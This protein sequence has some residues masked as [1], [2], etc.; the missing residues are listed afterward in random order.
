[1]SL[2]SWQCR[3]EGLDSGLYAGTVMGLRGTDSDDVSILNTKY[4]AVTMGPFQFSTPGIFLYMAQYA[5]YIIYTSDIQLE[6]SPCPD[7]QTVRAMM[8]NLQK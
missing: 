8:L 1:M 7:R 6:M 4:E 2:D 3:W 5:I